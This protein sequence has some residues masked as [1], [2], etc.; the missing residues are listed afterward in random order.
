MTRAWDK[1]KSESL[2]GIEPVTVVNTT[3]W[4][5]ERDLN[6]RPTDLKF[7]ALTIRPCCLHE[8]KHYLNNDILS[9]IYKC[10]HRDMNLA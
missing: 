7:G 1:E 9:L 2:T 8:I 3:S 5:S 6:T 10:R 4:W